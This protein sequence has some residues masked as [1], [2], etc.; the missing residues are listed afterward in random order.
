MGDSEESGP[1]SESEIFAQLERLLRSARFASAATQ[2]RL[3]RLVVQKTIANEPTNEMALGLELFENFRAASHTVRSNANLL[4]GRIAEYYHNEGKDDLVRITLPP[5]PAYKASFAYHSNA[6]ALRRYKYG[7]MWKNHATYGQLFW[8]GLALHDVTQEYPEFRDAHLYEAES[9]LI[10]GCFERA[11][12]LHKIPSARCP[13]T[14]IAKAAEKLD[15]ES[16]HPHIIYGV[17]SLM[18]YRWKEAGRHFAE[19]LRLDERTTNRSLWYALYLMTVGEVDHAIHIAESNYKE[20]PHNVGIVSVCA[21]LFYFKRD[22]AEALTMT[23]SLY[24]MDHYGSCLLLLEGL[25]ELGSGEAQR[26][27]WNFRRFSKLEPDD[28]ATVTIATSPY[29]ASHPRSF[30]LI[31]LSLASIGRLEEAVNIT[32]E[33]HVYPEESPAV[34]GSYKKLY[35]D[36]FQAAIG[37]MAVSR[38][39]RAL[40]CLERSY[41]LEDVL[42]TWLHLMPFFDPLR[43][44]PRFRNLLRRIKKGLKPISSARSSRS[45]PRIVPPA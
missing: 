13:A 31:A 17:Q 43:N 14:E 26:A 12:G 27:L 28:W 21:L 24:E 23:H 16:C 30:G 40:A 25:I 5:G 2:S 11:L 45:R 41:R 1:P 36:Q 38:F 3:L 4:R 18:L 6:D 8:G 9:W 7:T 39:G 15:P 22:F 32:R 33:V 34:R 29:D 37:Y 10:S 42:L 20:Y 44:H 19:A 35:T